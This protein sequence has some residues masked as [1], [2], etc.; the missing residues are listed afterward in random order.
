VYQKLSISAN[1][2][3]LYCLNFSYGLLLTYT[4]GCLFIANVYIQY[5]SVNY[6]YHCKQQHDA[7]Y[8]AFSSL[9]NIRYDFRIA[10][11][12]RR[13][14]PPLFTTNNIQKRWALLQTTYRRDEPSYKQHTEEMSPPT[15][16]IQKRWALLQTTL[17]CMLFVGGIISSVCCL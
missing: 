11:C 17:F 10:R 5:W 16:N 1:I 4:D 7:L 8:M 6:A 9:C 13:L 3:I 14:C 15:N 12:S 2:Y